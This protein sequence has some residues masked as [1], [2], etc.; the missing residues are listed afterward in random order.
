MEILITPK[1]F[2]YVY[3]LIR[4]KIP[5]CTLGRDTFSRST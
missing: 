5:E 4:I 2:V 3:A 1:E